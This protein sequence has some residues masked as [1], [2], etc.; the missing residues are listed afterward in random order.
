MPAENLNLRMLMPHTPTL[1][2][3]AWQHAVALHLVGEEHG[4]SNGK[5]CVVR[6]GSLAYLSD[7]W[8]WKLKSQLHVFLYRVVLQRT[9]T[10]QQ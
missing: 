8:V 3:V 7:H 1:S 9:T 10:Q 6:T 4:M 5:P 2:P